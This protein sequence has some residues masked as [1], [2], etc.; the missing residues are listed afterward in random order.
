[1]YQFLI[2]QADED[3]KKLLLALTFL[4]IS[5]IDTIMK[6]HEENKA[7]R[8]AQTTL[9]QTIVNDIYG[10][11]EVGKCIRI[12]E[13]LFSGKL[14]ELDVKDIKVALNGVPTF[15]AELDQYDIC[16]LLVNAQVVP[17]KSNARQLIQSNSISVNGKLITDIH[18][19]I[20]KHEA[21]GEDEKFSYIR[22]GK[23]NYFLVNWK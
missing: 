6:K 21:K 11:Q 1:M 4:S 7:L 14:E 10:P 19:M 16:D 2:N 18:Q 15:N 8:Y 23:K 17:S 12:S 22:K 5:D 3:V 9:A 20:S 13:T